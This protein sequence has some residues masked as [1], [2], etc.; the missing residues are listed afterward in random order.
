[1]SRRVLVVITVVSCADSTAAI[2]TFA[3]RSIVTVTVTLAM[4]VIRFVAGVA[5]RLAC[6]CRG[7]TL[8]LK[9]VNFVQR[10]RDGCLRV[11]IRIRGWTSRS[12]SGLLLA[13]V[14]RHRHPLGRRGRSVRS[15][16]H[17]IVTDRNVFRYCLGLS[18]GNR[19]GGCTGGS[20]LRHLTLARRDRNS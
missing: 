14:L 11:S 18:F 13:T 20:S 12:R 16:W 19:S 5:A 9:C 17:V 10:A 4:A 7:S 3:A 2:G 6:G 15:C 1:M 8:R